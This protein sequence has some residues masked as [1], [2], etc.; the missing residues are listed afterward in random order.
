[1]IGEGAGGSDRLAGQNPRFFMGGVSE[2]VLSF[3]LPAGTAIGRQRFGML[4]MPAGASC[5]LRVT[6]APRRQT[7]QTE[8]GRTGPAAVSVLYS[9]AEIAEIAGT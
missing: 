6:Q 7:Q 5:G 2:Y 1:M 3:E 9:T 4:R 8:G